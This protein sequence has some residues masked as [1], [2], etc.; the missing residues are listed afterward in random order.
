MYDNTVIT[1]CDNAFI[2]KAKTHILFQHPFWGTILSMLPI[3]LTSD[4]PTAATDGK[5]I[6][7]NPS[8]IE[9]KI[10]E[11]FVF[12]VM[13]EILHVI[14]FH[15]DKKRLCDR[16]PQLWNIA[17]DYIV[18]SILDKNGYPHP[19]GAL[20]NDKYDDEYTVEKLYDVLMKDIDKLLA[21]YSGNGD[22]VFSDLSPQD[23]DLIKQAVTAGRDVGKMAGNIPSGLSEIVD[24]LLNPKVPWYVIL[25]RY[26]KEIIGLKDDYTY[27]RP[28]R[29][30]DDLVV[31]SAYNGEAI[32]TVVVAIDSSGSVTSDELKNFVSEVAGITNW[33]KEMYVLTCDTEVYECEHIY[34]AGDKISSMQI[35][36]RGGTMFQPVFDW[37]R[38]KGIR[39]DVL[40]YMT[41]GY[42]D[43]PEKVGYPVIWLICNDRVN[44]PWGTTI[45]V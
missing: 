29:K 31:P 34:E 38:D 33:V 4:V 24:N 44:P 45:R 2:R 41:D 30:Y 19:E 11:E 17:A 26:V 1:T 14:L 22:I 43:F 25:R 37:V 23:Q 21:N 20:Y 27:T 3:K 5:R 40:V 39:P 13:H 6:M 12:I 36:G 35:R 10:F 28:N 16:N 42:A 15:T 9:G 7:M 8:F 32:S 18:N